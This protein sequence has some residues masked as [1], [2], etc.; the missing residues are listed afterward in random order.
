MLYTIA[1]LILPI[2]C[3]ILLGIALIFIPQQKIIA[4]IRF[5]N[6]TLTPGSTIKT[7]TGLQGILITGNKT[8]III[9]TA[10]GQKHEILKHLI[11]QNETS[12]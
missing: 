5:T 2:T 10:D 12:L 8:H 6:R 1:T 11:V 7:T 4:Q 3:I 9:G